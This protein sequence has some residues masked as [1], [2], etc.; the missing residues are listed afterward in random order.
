MRQTIKVN[1]GGFQTHD[2]ESS[3]RSTPQEIARDLVSQMQPLAASSVPIRAKMEELKK[4][5]NV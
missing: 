2:F 1:L 4:A 5:Y 3:E